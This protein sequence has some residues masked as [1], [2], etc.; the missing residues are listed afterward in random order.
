MNELQ[1][2]IEFPFA[3]LPQPA[4]LFQPSEGA[5][6]DSAFGQHYKCM[7]FIA[8]DDLHG[9]FQALLYV[10]GEL[11][12]GVAAIDRHAFNSLQ[13]RPPAVD[14]LQGSA[15]IGRLGCGNRDNMGQPP[16]IHPDAP[17]DAGNLLARA[18]SI[19]LGAIGV[20]HALR[21]NNQEASYGAASLFGAGLANR[22]FKARSRTPIPSGPNSL[23]LAK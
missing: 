15:A 12:P 2:G 6:D 11:L 22:L 7:R 9:G 3:V 14:N 20:L 13:I 10:T 19:L 4:A 5:F 21:V 8:L 18:V 23:H 17:L 1:A 16:R